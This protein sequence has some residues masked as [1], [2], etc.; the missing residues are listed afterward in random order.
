MRILLLPFLVISVSLLHSN[1]TEIKCSHSGYAGK[2]LDFYQYAD[3]VTQNSHILFSLDFDSDGNSR[4][5]APVKNTT[6]AFCD[7]GIYRGMLYLEP[8][9]TIRLELPPVR[10]KSFADRKNPFFEPVSFW[11]LTAEDTDLNN[12]ISKFTIQ[13]NKLTDKYFNHL[14]FRRSKDALDSLTSIL[15]EKFTSINDPAFEAHKNFTLKMVE[16]D[17]F[18][19]KPESY[20]R[21]FSSVSPDLWA[22]QS[23]ISLFDKND[24]HQQQ[25]RRTQCK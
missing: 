15:G 24:K 19:M 21:Y 8:G 18:R 3:P 17:M 10:E 14:Y 16:V 22:F 6:Y 4:V 2:T 12:Q 7:F 23:F 25:N 20:S 9:K 13:F 11:F 5:T 1:A